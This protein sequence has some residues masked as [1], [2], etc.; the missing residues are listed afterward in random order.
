MH[1]NTAEFHNY[2]RVTIKCRL[3]A[4]NICV[5]FHFIRKFCYEEAVEKMNVP[6][7]LIYLY[8]TSK[9]SL[10]L[11]CIIFS[12]RSATQLIDGMGNGMMVMPQ[13]RGLYELGYPPT[14]RVFSYG[15]GYFIVVFAKAF[16]GKRNFTVITHWRLFNFFYYRIFI[17]SCSL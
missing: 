2:V 15:L 1:C 17:T 4:E 7:V 13:I 9:T 3:F 12:W 5:P 8:C 10:V 11:S 6:F 14:G 16:C